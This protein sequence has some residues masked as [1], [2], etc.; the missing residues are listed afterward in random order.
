MGKNLNQITLN[1][2]KVKQTIASTA[3]TYD[4]S[5]D[6]IHL[7]AVSKRHSV[8]AVNVAYASGQ[9]HFGENFVSE[10]IDK[11]ARAPDDACWHF[12]GAIQ[13]NKTRQ[14]AAHYDWVHTVDRLK[15]AQRLSDQREADQP[16]R[17][18]VQVNLGGGSSRAGVEP[19]D[20]LELAAAVHELPG[21]ALRGL[22]VLPPPETELAAQR[23]HFA[24]IAKLAAAG[25]DRSLPLTELS[26][27]MSGDLAAAIAEG[28]TW[29]RI[30][31]AIFGQ[32]PES[33]LSL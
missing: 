8:D 16:L 1:L 14:I 19:D 2:A 5:G 32:R 28:A 7:L 25:R 15:V 21:L 13:S 30:G 9:R 11:M 29:L 12:I 26:M 3:S 6:Q 27:G 22:M 31:T 23:R 24:Q 20:T 33:A 18:C 10:G 17:V 4:R